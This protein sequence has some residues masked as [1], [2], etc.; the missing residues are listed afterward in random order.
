[1]AFYDEESC[2]RSFANK[3]K[4]N[5]TEGDSD[6]NMEEGDV[7]CKRIGGAL[8]LIDRNSGKIEIRG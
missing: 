8:M 6:G 4:T 1:M 2:R 3:G 7:D 5:K